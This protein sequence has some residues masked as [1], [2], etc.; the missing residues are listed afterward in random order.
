MKKITVFYADN[1]EEIEYY[2]EWKFAIDGTIVRQEEFHY[3]P[4]SKRIEW[5]EDQCKKARKRKKPTFFFTNDYYFMRLLEKSGGDDFSIHHVN[6][7]ET[8]YK[9]IDLKPN[10]ALDICNHITTW[11][12]KRGLKQV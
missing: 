10:Y 9:F 3:T 8:V 4:L 1:I 5:V 2:I 7:G 6:S 12:M 11:T